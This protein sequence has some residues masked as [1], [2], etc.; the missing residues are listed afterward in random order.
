VGFA[1]GLAVIGTTLIVGVVSTTI[2]ALKF[3]I[4]TLLEDVDS[5][6]TETLK[7]VIIT[8]LEEVTFTTIGVFKFVTPTLLEGVVS[9]TT[10]VVEVVIITLLE[11][12][13]F[14][15]IGAFGIVIITL[16]EAV[17]FSTIGAFKLVIITV[18]AV[19]SDHRAEFEK[20]IAFISG[21]VALQ[22]PWSMCS[23]RRYFNPIAASLLE[24]ASSF[25]SLLLILGKPLFPSVFNKRAGED[26]R[27]EP[28]ITFSGR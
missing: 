10:G 6:H 19:V 13:T 18:V 17:T 14:T 11:E 2:V 27:Y 22:R 15:T 23:G 20:I 25:E 7:F 12:V 16:L 4:I 8:L 5:T 24:R 9:T 1:G 21:V 3:V 26:I 28:F